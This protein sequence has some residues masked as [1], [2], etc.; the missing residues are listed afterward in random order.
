MQDPFVSVIVPTY[1]GTQF[2]QPCLTSVFQSDYTNF[3]VVMVDDCSTDGS[4]EYARQLFGHLPNFRLFRNSTNLGAAGSRNVGAENARGDLLVFLDDDATVDLKWL[5][6]FVQAMKLYPHVGAMQSKMLGADD[7]LVCAGERLIPYIGW[8]I[9][10]GFEE[11]EDNSYNEIADICAS[12]GALAVKRDVFTLV[13]G[14]DPGM[15]F[16]QFEDL[17]FSLR[18]WL[19]GHRVILVPHS[20]VWHDARL[21]GSNPKRHRLIQ[22][23]SQRNCI[24]MLLKNYSLG[25]LFRYLPTSIM[26]MLFRSLYALIRKGDVYSLLGLLKAIFWN[27]AHLPSTVRERKRVQRSV[28]KV[29]DEYLFRKVGI[30]LS[31]FHIY[32][33]YLSQGRTF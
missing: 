20:I 17:D 31:P 25:N 7:R 22:Y 26:A 9:L 14:F 4:S 10:R 8:V 32:K 18:I 6:A 23:V 21:K 30:S 11:A 2:I 24:R 12:S 27:L 33:Y 19:S 5:G 15:A 16:N 29:T 28:R 1:N 3:E 13:G